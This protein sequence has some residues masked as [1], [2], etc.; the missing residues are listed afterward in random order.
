[1]GSRPGRG[2]KAAWLARG[3][4][5]RARR[6]CSD[7]RDGW[8]HGR[9]VQTSPD[10]GSG[11]QASSYVAGAFAFLAMVQA[12]SEQDGRSIGAQAGPSTVAADRGRFPRLRRGRWVLVVDEH[13]LLVDRSG[14]K[15]VTRAPVPGDPSGRLRHRA[16]RRRRVGSGFGRRLLVLGVEGRA[17]PFLVLLLREHEERQGSAD[18]DRHQPRDVGQLVALQERRLGGADDLVAVL[19]VLL[20]EVGGARVGELELALRA[21]RSRPGPTRRWRC[22]W[23]PRSRPSAAHRRSTS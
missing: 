12:S 20:G 7:A 8:T 5:L 6:P 11:A 1:M 4:R 18:D 9:A 21:W 14:A 13:T 10:G 19:R 3:T 2:S 15:G 17:H 22:P 23:P 16:G